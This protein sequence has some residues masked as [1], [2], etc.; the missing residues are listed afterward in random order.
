MDKMK[1]VAFLRSALCLAAEEAYKSE[2]IDT[3]SEDEIG[4]GC[5]W[6]TKQ[7]WIY[8]RILGWVEEASGK[9][10]LFND[11]DR[12]V[13]DQSL[14]I[15]DAYYKCPIGKKFKLDSGIEIIR[16]PGGWIHN[17]TNAGTF[18]S[19]FIPYS[20]EFDDMVED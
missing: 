11:D 20:D 13:D 7:E 2:I 4:D 10:I 1:N 19:V 14:E 17:T 8:S 18:A 3:N 16:V 15:S 5:E 6:S 12:D 9:I